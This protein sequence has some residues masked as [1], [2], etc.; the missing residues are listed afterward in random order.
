MFPR[1]EQGGNSDSMFWLMDFGWYSTL[2]DDRPENASADL[3]V[4]RGVSAHC[5]GP[6]LGCRQL[7]SQ[8][9]ER[10]V[11]IREPASQPTTELVQH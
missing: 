1:V 11:G 7:A 3:T 5:M 4:G 10:L 2:S 6:E 9:I 8:Q